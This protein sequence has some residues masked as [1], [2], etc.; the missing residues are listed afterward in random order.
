MSGVDQMKIPGNTVK[1]VE[2]RNIPW[3]QQVDEASY[4]N[5]SSPTQDEV[6]AA[7]E[8]SMQFQ[9]PPFNFKE[10]CSAPW[11]NM[12]KGRKINANHESYKRHGHSI[13]NNTRRDD[14]QVNPWNS[15]K[16]VTQTIRNENDHPSST[17]LDNRASDEA[18]NH[19]VVAAPKKTTW[20]SIA[21]QP[22]KLT[23]R[24]ASTT[25]NNK[26]KGPGMPPPPM[27]PGKHNLDVNVWDLP[28]NKPPLVPSPPSPIDLGYSDLSSDFSISGNN[29]GQAPQL[30]TRT[31]KVHKDTENF[32]KYENKGLGTNINHNHHN[33]NNFNRAKISPTGP[34][35]NPRNMGSIQQHHPAQQHHAA[36]RPANNAGP[37]PFGPPNNQARRHDGAGGAPHPNRNIERS[38]NHY[39]SFRSNSDFE[40]TPKF[41]YREENHSRP[42]EATST[43]EEVPVDPQLLLDELKDKNNYNPKVVDLNKATSTRFFVIKSYSE[44]DI[45]RS[46]KYEIWC[47]TDHGNKRLDDAFKERH[48]EGGN[49]MLF[50]SVNGSGHFCGM[51][52]MM[53]AV[54][55]NSTSSV[56]SQDK[57]KGKFKVKWIYVKD[58]PN[59]KLRHIRLENNDNKSVT[60]S[61]D[62]Q[63]VPNDKG[64]EVLQILHSYNHSTSIFDDFFHYEK[65]Q[66]EEVSSKRPPLHGPEGN[67]QA[68]APLSRSFNRHTDD[69]EPRERDSRSGGGGMSQKHFNAGG[70]GFRNPIHRAGGSNYSEYRRGNDYQFKDRDSLDFDREN[71]FG[72]HYGGANSRKNEYQQNNTNK[73]RLKNRDRDFSTEQMKIDVRFRAGLSTSKDLPRDTD[74]DK[75]RSN[76]YS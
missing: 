37:G 57:W 67:S 30:G 25:S 1:S 53:T 70:A 72:A 32:Q 76:E 26:K 60:N 63:E 15:R 3:S 22:A 6:S 2:E 9:Y 10:N 48:K 45:H 16:P 17:K 61:R 23:S 56:W 69:K 65:K 64:I 19:E 58:V 12:N 42:V 28:N 24:T 33:N 20:A 5:L 51:A 40:N 47:S 34:V 31:E 36:P 13:P 75:M 74:K 50:F 39:S 71:D 29:H 73:S 49:I 38:G 59:G 43:T 68:Q 52:Q 66:E 4:E 7:N 44:D 21:S 11:S 27:V 55:Y 8:N 14:L 35:R 46:I 41:E 54:D 62:T 18:Q